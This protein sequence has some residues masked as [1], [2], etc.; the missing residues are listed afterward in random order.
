MGGGPAGASGTGGVSR[1]GA[2][3]RTGVGGGGTTGLGGSGVPGCDVTLG[4]GPQPVA[5]FS[6]DGSVVA[7]SSPGRAPE[8]R[9][10][11]DD[12]PLPLSEN[13]RD[14]AVMAF[15]S[16]GALFAAATLD[17]L[18]VWRVSDGQLLHR[19]PDFAGASAIA[20]S[21]AG[22]VIAAIVD[23]VTDPPTARVWRLA[24]PGNIRT[25][26]GSHP[27]LQFSGPVTPI[28][29][30]VAPDGAHV[31]LMYVG[32]TALL[33]LFPYVDEWA[34][35]DGAATWS[36]AYT[37]NAP[38]PASARLL[39]SPDGTTVLV[40]LAPLDVLDAATGTLIRQLGPFMTTQ[41][42][43]VSFGPRAFSTDGTM[44]VGI[45]G[46]SEQPKP[47]QVRL[48]DGAVLTPLTPPNETLIGVGI[49]TGPG[50]ASLVVDR[51][52]TAFV[53]T[54]NGTRVGS[55]DAYS[56]AS[57]GGPVFLSAN[58][59][60]VAIDQEQSTPAA[61]AP[62]MTL[63]WDTSAAIPV[64]SVS[65]G[66]W[67]ASA[68]D[69]FVLYSVSGTHLLATPV[70]SSAASYD[71]DTGGS[72]NLGLAMS[73]SGAFIGIPGPEY[74]AQVRRAANGALLS[75]LWDIQGHTDFVWAVAFSPDEKWIATGSDDKRIRL[76]DAATGAGGAFLTGARAGVSSLAFTPD[77]SAIVSADESGDL[78]L[79]NVAAGTTS[80]MT[81]VAGGVTD[82]AVSPDG[83][84]V[85]VS[86]GKRDGTGVNDG[87]ILRFHLPDW[88]SLPPLPGRGS[89]VYDIALS[90]DGTRL[91]AA[92]GGTVR[93]YCIE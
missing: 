25:L 58:G 62:R 88:A 55:H 64:K 1:G 75:T 48:S 30:A 14:S 24:D 44:L 74:T 86:V 22:D 87:D 12:S 35:A 56:F 26:V 9:H 59:L 61:A 65:T 37:V 33:N 57:A 84:V 19:I 15:S 13:E 54:E 17:A 77:G 80:T 23:T 51:T 38:F 91:A 92:S 39:F 89:T 16:D 31:V 81:N 50:Y 32:H 73:P 41:G 42:G 72:F 53:Y 90:K 6:P 28:S 60:F 52:E 93:L 7:L 20:L 71:V 3:G 78:R 68:P 66:S 85:Y 63:L 79:W 82:L 45:S 47:A 5:L 69:S 70:A 18:N 4:W 11:P 83:S 34:T 40:T 29:V 49:G 27:P 43:S 2:G 8:L 76:W 21:T 10:W 36:H 46:T 67:L